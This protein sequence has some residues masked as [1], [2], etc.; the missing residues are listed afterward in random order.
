[1][2]A[3]A[4]PVVARAPRGYPRQQGLTCGEYNARGV[5]E[6]FGVPFRPPAVPRLRI[7]MFGYSF[8][9]DISDLLEAHGISA[10]V[11]H[12]ATLSADQKLG[13][14]R[15]HID[16]G[17]PVIMAIGN[18]HLRRGYY[19][20]LAR[21]FVGHF[22]TVYGYSTDEDA[23]FIYDPYLEG[24]FHERIPVGN[25]VRTSREMLRDWAGTF[26]YRLVGMN[27]VYIPTALRG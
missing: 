4:N 15:N 2:S 21:H 7:R 6:A 1:M 17:Q 22:I 13:A 25:E 24:E 27:H 12:A 16:Q 11:R 26:Y 8:V 19:L 9:Q 18:G 14:I 23:F 20:P 3:G 5:V 10:P